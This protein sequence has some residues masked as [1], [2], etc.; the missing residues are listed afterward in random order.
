M[1]RNTNMLPTNALERG[2]EVGRKR[3]DP[4]DALA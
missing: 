3:R 2:F 4:L 1:V